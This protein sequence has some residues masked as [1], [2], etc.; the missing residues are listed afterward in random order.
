MNSA[1]DAC[2]VLCA[3]MTSQVCAPARHPG[4]PLLNGDPEF[5][6]F[7]RKPQRIVAAFNRTRLTFSLFPAPALGGDANEFAGSKSAIDPLGTTAAAIVA[8]A[9]SAGRIMPSVN[10]KHAPLERLCRASKGAQL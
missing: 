4:N 8:V 1:D 6:G 10:V 7:V 5:R 9:L 3:V 2:A